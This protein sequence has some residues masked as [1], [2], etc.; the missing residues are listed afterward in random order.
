[1]ENT[2]IRI[3]EK[4]FIVYF[5]GYF[6]IDIF[7]FI[8]FLLTFKSDKKKYEIEIENPGLFHKT[9]VIV[10]AYNEEVSILHCIQ[11]LG[12]LD[13]SDFEIVIVNDGSKD[14]TLNTLLNTFD[15][16]PVE[17]RFFNS[18]NFIRTALVR[19]VYSADNGKI[20]LVDKI[21]GGKA[22]SVNAGINFSHGEFVCTIDA[23]SILDRGSLKQI[24]KP[25]IIDE[26]VIVTGGQLAVSNETV[27]EG[28]K[29]VNFKMPKNI[30]VLFQ[31]TEYIKSF[32]VSRIGLSKINSL[33]IM[34]G[35]FS[36][37]RR[38]DLINIGGFLT[39][40]NNHKYLCEIFK[41]EKKNTVCEDMEIVVRLSRYYLEK[42]IKGK[43]V[44]LAKPLCWTEVPDNSTNLFKQRARW[45]LGLAECLFMHSKM[46]FDPKYS[47]TGLLA[48][49]YY[50]FL[51]FLSP[52][53][54]IL[55]IIFIVIVS[56]RGLINIK[57]VMLMLLFITI[58]TALITSILTVFIENWSEKSAVR[59]RDALRY[60][61]IF[62]WFKLL[63]ISIIGDFTYYFFKISA[64]L[65]GTIDFFRKKS[66]WNKFE[67]RGLQKIVTQTNEIKL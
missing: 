10:P 44:Y 16:K 60:K 67:R 20:I 59:N 63:L 52:V 61:T 12:N 65:K 45:H 24:V 50:F 38:K 47:T 8:I 40:E 66:E 46:F 48:F 26:R 28:D 41:E 4:L 29:I 62:D 32:L 30:W 14:E 37:Y 9:S 54:K 25:M 33:L 39:S 6:F 27:I 5:I 22:D 15:F 23:D 49:P 56:Y 53:I 7:L 11:M 18:E 2:V 43:V 55:S 36:L 57:W 1:M 3:I 58:T 35:A 31:I 13:Y 34:S 42:N 19:N 64:Q 51:E 21:N 17:N